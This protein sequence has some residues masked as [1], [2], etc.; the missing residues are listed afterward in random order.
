MELRIKVFDNLYNIQHC[1]MVLNE[2][3]A[4]VEK[5]A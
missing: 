4:P 2:K 3:C 5:H 1:E